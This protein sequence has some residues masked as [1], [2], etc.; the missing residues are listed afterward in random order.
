MFQCVQIQLQQN[1]QNV[2]KAFSPLPQV[3]VYLMENSTKPFKEQIWLR[4]FL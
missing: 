4:H 2:M 1:A 3:N